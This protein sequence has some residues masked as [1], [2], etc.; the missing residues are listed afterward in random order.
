MHTTYTMKM[1][2]DKRPPI[3]GTLR[4]ARVYATSSLFIAHY[5][6]VVTITQIG[7]DVTR[8]HFSCVL[9]FCFRK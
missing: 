9:Q 2:F 4:H 6:P 7:A 5:Q 1:V 3:G 8:S